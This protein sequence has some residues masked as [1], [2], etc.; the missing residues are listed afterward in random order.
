[1]TRHRGLLPPIHRRAVLAGA[2]I[3]LLASVVLA[4]EVSGELVI[5]QWQGG[6]DLEMWHEV[7]AKFME[8]HPGV[9][10]REFVPAGGQG[11]ARGG[12]VRFPEA[13]A[14]IGRVMVHGS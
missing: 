6:T 8:M 4:R 13:P 7:E 3:A 14:E 12:I 5:M 1:M 9:T 11:D 2:A 10:V